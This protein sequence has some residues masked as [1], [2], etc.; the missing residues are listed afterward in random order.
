MAL[1]PIL[2][3][4]WTKIRT[5]ASTRWTLATVLAVTAAMGAGLC[6][7]VDATWDQLPAVERAT[8]DATQ[9]SFSGMMLG[10]L[11]VLVFGAMVVGTEYSSGMIRTS[12]AAVPRRGTLLLGKVAVATGLALVV[13]LATGFVSFFLGQALLGDH[14]VG[15]D[16]ENVL[17]AVTGVGLY[18]ALLTAFAIGIAMMLRNSAASVCIL[19]AF[20]LIL[21]MVLGVVDA[22]RKVAYY[23]PNS[24]GSAIMQTV[25][26]GP[27]VPYGPW[28]GLGIM[29]LWALA[30]VAGGLLVLKKRDA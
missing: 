24:A 8:F 3:S 28:G 4:E 17:R 23:L 6:A 18:L 12:L 15:L 25:P 26:A 22:T 20:I 14:S 5:V 9:M 7:L 2:R 27:D 21:P 29:A 1:S 11:A 10:Q 13:G 19:I 16:G 30:A